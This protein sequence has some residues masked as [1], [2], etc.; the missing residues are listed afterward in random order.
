MAVSIGDAVLKLGVD[1]KDLDKGMQGL[2]GKLQKHSKAIGIGMTAMG[3]AI[4]AA[5]A[6][7]IKTFAAMGDEV[8][9]MALRTGFSTEALSELRH[10]AELSGTSL[11]SLE[12]ASKTLSGAILDAGFGLETYVRAFDKIGLSYEQLK[13]L[14][15][16]DQFLAVM[17][18]L[19]GVTD[20]SEKAA[21]AAD[22]FGRAGTQ[23]LPMLADGT[24]GLKAMRQEA[25]ELGIVFDQ[26]AADKA[27]EFNDA[28]T[29][30]KGAVSGL[31][32]TMA[33]V[34]VPTLI[35]VIDKI[36]DVVVGLTEWAK[37]HETLTKI[38]IF[39]TTALGG[40]LVVLG[41]IIIMLDSL[42]DIW[43]A[44]KVVMMSKVLPAIAKVTAALWAK[45]AA[46]YAAMVAMGPKGWA[47]AAIAMGIIAA[48][49]VSIIKKAREATSAFTGEVEEYTP[50][51]READDATRQW[52]EG[53][54]KLEAVTRRIT[55]A[56][57]KLTA[58]TEKL[59]EQSDGVAGVTSFLI[60]E[61]SSLANILEQEMLKTE[62]LSQAYE[63]FVDVI[64][65]MEDPSDRHI[66]Y[67]REYIELKG[68]ATE[69]EREH[70]KELEETTK[71]LEEQA[72][73]QKK[74]LEEVAEARKRAT[75]TVEDAIEAL[76]Y[77][78]SEA[79]KLNITIKDVINVLNSMG[80]TNN[81]IASTLIS[82]GDEQ[83]NVLTVLDA[84]GLEALSVAIEL[85]IMSDAL[86]AY[87]DEALLSAG[88]TQE[89]IDKLREMY[90]ITPPVTPVTPVTPAVPE[91]PKEPMTSEEWEAWIAQI[92]AAGTFGSQAAFDA[93]IAQAYLMIGRV[94]QPGP[95]PLGGYPRI[96]EIF[97][98]LPPG[99][100]PELPPGAGAPGLG[101]LQHGGIAM[102]PMIAAIAEKKP[103]AV[104]PLDRL[105]GMIGGKQMMT[106]IYEVDGRQM[107]RTIMPYAVGE[108]RLKTGVHI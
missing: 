32:M 45:V 27:A 17:E 30:V 3:G 106:I 25:H 52:S 5:G 96:G 103:E 95:I 50:A 44:V 92:K 24:E 71:L 47:M 70:Q 18:A 68:E 81:Y 12:K 10:A 57:D 48:G 101:L 28:L 63:D 88:A 26:E 31:K 87:T 54:S 46:L 43:M 33:E 35:S 69:A 78:R 55:D 34:L 58:V 51:A 42:I 94:W 107:A 60:T 49:L 74:A 40:V 86:A 16:E 83:N 59:K 93:F 82:L 89:Y 23:L 4:L 65:A 41:P 39:F 91:L 8:A 62:G 105:E 14:S 85:G 102:S 13:G 84:F 21:L 67:L 29:R 61:G 108:I 66:E 11:S 15:P 7:S 6:L 2:K 104:I 75:E 77:E 90:G 80:K 38:M 98:E 53:L 1:T 56:E 37:Q 36:K 20:E 99:L 19:A 79:G 72:E 73:A 76:Q 64:L 22:I 100:P 9:K 97:P